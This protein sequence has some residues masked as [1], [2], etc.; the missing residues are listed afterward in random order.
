MTDTSK[1]TWVVIL[2][3]VSPIIVVVTLF[4][5]VGGARQQLD[6]VVSEVKI[7][8]EELRIRTRDRIHRDEHDRDVSEL[9]SQLAELRR[10]IT[11]N[12]GFIFDHR[13][14]ETNRVS[15]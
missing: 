5:D 11:R 12:E 3:I 10:R 2:S 6:T 1:N 13:P 4:A 9:R 14:N 15:P 7:I 8:R